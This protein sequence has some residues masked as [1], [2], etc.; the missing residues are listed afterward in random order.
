MVPNIGRSGRV[1]RAITGAICLVVG[2]CV[3][4]FAWNDTPTLRWIVSGALVVAGAFQLFEAQKGWC[5]MRACGVKT[6]M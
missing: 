3:A 5:V 6:P 4:L 2:I 1:A